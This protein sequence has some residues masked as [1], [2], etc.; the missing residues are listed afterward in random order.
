MSTV[1]EAVVESGE[2][3]QSTAGAVCVK[4]ALLRDLK[5]TKKKIVDENVDES[6]S[7]EEVLKTNV[8]E[9]EN[10]DLKK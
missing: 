2:K 4:P 6:A 9:S 1:K 3:D 8:E 7:V 10:A 5:I